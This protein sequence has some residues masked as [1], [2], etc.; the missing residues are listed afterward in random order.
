VMAY[1]DAE[2][3]GDDGPPNPRNVEEQ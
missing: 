2:S 3:S 1:A